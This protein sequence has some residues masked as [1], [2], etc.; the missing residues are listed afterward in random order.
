MV[1][2]LVKNTVIAQ[3]P[4]KIIGVFIPTLGILSSIYLNFRGLIVENKLAQ[5]FTYRVN[6]RTE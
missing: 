4:I 3:V 5:F 2:G 1:N 6:T